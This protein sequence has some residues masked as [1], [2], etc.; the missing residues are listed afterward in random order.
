MSLQRSFPMFL[1]QICL[2]G[3]DKCF[4]HPINLGHH[5]MDKGGM[6]EMSTCSGVIR[7][8]KPSVVWKPSVLEKHGT[9]KLI[10]ALPLTQL[11]L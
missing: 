4:C 10:K 3:N 7:E 8:V 5:K 9:Q 1:L 11:A 2:L 6:G